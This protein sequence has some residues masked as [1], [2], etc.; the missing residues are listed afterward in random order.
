[1][2]E[3]EKTKQEE[4]QPISICGLFFLLLRANK[5]HTYLPKVEMPRSA[6]HKASMDRALAQKW[7]LCVDG[8]QNNQPNACASE[9]RRHRRAVNNEAY[10]TRAV[11][12]V[13]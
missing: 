6:P 1:M 12:D 2:N 8:T 11:V 9:R 4:N 3:I 13:L 5:T 10:T 7:K